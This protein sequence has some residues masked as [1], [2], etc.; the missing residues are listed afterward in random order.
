MKKGFTLIEVAVAAA[1]VGILLSAQ[2]T[3]IS[4]YMRSYLSCVAESSESFYAEEAFFYLCYITDHAS[5][6]DA[7][8]GII[9]LV[10]RDG[11]GSD[12]IRLDRDGD[13]VISYGSCFSGTTNNIMKKLE[14]FEVEQKGLLL[15]ITLNTQ[16]GN[17]YKKC[18]I[19]KV[20]KEEASCSY[21]HFS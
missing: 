13:L 6:V 11:T 8:N 21:I 16:E 14:S 2:G 9:E 10:R 7:D 17:E 3:V 1:L 12:W 20:K 5:C 19:I 18:I 4:R 15:F